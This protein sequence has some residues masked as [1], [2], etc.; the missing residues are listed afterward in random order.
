M[1]W[2]IWVDAEPRKAEHQLLEIHF[3]PALT[4]MHRY[5]ELALGTVGPR[6]D[7]AWSQAQK[8]A[9]GKLVAVE[10]TPPSWSWVK[11]SSEEIHLLEAK[12]S[13]FKRVNQELVKQLRDRTTGVVPLEAD[14]A[15][16]KLRLK[17]AMEMLTQSRRYADEV[18]HENTELRN[19][20]RRRVS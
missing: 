5:M 4:Q 20:Q 7:S 6:P 18:V 14:W 13:E 12:L 19:K 2:L 8:P 10:N 1:D 15:D 16:L 11:R 9:P 3:D 17:T